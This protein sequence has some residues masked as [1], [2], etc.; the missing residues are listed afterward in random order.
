[1]ACNLFQDM[2]KYTGSLIKDMERWSKIVIPIFFLIFNIIYWSV[3]AS[4]FFDDKFKYD[5]VKV[6]KK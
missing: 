6:H 1:M 2:K 4:Q 3:Y 5:W